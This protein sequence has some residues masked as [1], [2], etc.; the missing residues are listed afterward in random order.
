MKLFKSIAVAATCFSLIAGAGAVSTQAATLGVNPLQSPVPTATRR[1][2]TTVVCTVLRGI[3]L[4]VRA[5][6]SIR[7]RK[8][9]SLR[10]GTSFVCLTRVGNWLSL[11]IRTR[12]GTRLGWVYRPYVR[13][14][15]AI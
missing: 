6:P 14:N 11:R 8:I 5:T 9:G 15:R 13:C 10:G 3:S 12:S 1:P 4:N 2:S 7:G